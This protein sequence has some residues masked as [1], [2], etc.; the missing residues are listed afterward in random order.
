M[1]YE[2]DRVGEFTFLEGDIVQFKVATDK[3]TKYKRAVEVIFV[4]NC[5]LTNKEKRECGIV[6]KVF[7]EFSNN[8]LQK[9][10][11]GAIKSIERDEL[12]YFLPNE[13]ISSQ[14]LKTFDSGDCLE[15]T[16]VENQKVKSFQPKFLLI[17]IFF[18]Y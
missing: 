13:F 17:L 2:R 7:S 18:V 15:F 11:Y 5:L 6:D 4:E 16:V 9:I 3:R 8:S 10:R 14:N 12:V 1:F